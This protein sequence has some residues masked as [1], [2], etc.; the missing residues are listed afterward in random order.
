MHGAGVTD[1]AS[2]DILGK[3]MYTLHH[4]HRHTFGVGDSGSAD[5][6]DGQKMAEIKQQL[7]EDSV[8]V[9]D[10]I[11]ALSG[12]ANNRGGSA[13]CAGDH[14]RVLIDE[15]G[16]GEGVGKRPRRQA[17]TAARTGPNATGV[18]DDTDAVCNPSLASVST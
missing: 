8:I 18:D 3:L 2:T 12:A 10:H 4:L 6:Y 1:D 15:A 17:A 5:L 16:D 9:G 11:E 13:A 14:K 7:I